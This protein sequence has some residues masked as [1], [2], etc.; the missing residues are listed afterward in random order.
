[1]TDPRGNLNPTGNETLHARAVVQ[2]EGLPDRITVDED[3]K[4][5]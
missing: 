4:L 3:I 1:M 5:G 2:I